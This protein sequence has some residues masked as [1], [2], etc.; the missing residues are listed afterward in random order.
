MV[1]FE[2]RLRRT[3]GPPA[4]FAAL[5]GVPAQHAANPQPPPSTTHPSLLT[6][7]PIPCSPTLTAP[8]VSS[9]TAPHCAIG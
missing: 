5:A 7:A 4:N 1:L 3:A 2:A 9:L 8:M 6:A